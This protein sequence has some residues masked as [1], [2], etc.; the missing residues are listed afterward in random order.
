MLYSGS[1]MTEDERRDLFLA[2]VGDET[3]PVDVVNEPPHYL[4]HPIF[5]RECI[6][7]TAHLAFESGNGFKYLYRCGKKGKA[8]ED[9]KKAHWYIRRVLLYKGGGDS[10]IPRTLL[11]EMKED[12][13]LYMEKH[14]EDIR[15]IDDGLLMYAIAAGVY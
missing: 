8:E 5:R 1:N 2:V 12:L 7:Y 13:N 10:D 9:R 11:V 3:P 14:P 15:T 6:E 4:G